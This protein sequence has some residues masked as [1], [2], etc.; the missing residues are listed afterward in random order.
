MRFG[1]WAI[2]VICLLACGPAIQLPSRGGPAWFEVRSEHF[3]LW[4]D[5]PVERGRDLVREMERRR[6]VI[7]TAM[8]SP[9]SRATAFVIMLREQLQVG[10]YVGGRFIASAWSDTN[11]TGQP[12]MLLA[13]DDKD[14]LHTA[15]H[16]L[17]QLISAQS[18]ANR[19]LW[20]RVG[21][22]NYFEVFDPRQGDTDVRVGIPRSDHLAILHWD[23]QPP[24]AWLFECQTARCNDRLF[25]GLSWA[26]SPCS[27]TSTPTSCAAIC[28]A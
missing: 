3:T 7:L 18:F 12:G 4:T 5:A 20:L 28:N 24:L 23:Y 2:A 6:Q 19:P 1:A 11:P 16:L 26:W 14:R 22:A 21:M 15:N 25:Q 27:S 17:A 13:E 8:S 10:D 9:A